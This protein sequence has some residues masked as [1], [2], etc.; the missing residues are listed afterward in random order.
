M[1]SPLWTNISNPSRFDSFELCGHL[2]QNGAIGLYL[3]VLGLVPS[4]N[5]LGRMRRCGLIGGGM[6]LG[7]LF[8]LR[9]WLVVQDV[10]IMA[11]AFNSPSSVY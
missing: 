4:W 3:C 10:S 6:S 8:V 5:F 9:L 7:L 2:N 11:H 1:Y